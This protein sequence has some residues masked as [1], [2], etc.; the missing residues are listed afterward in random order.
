[1]REQFQLRDRID[2]L[3]QRARNKRASKHQRRGGLERITAWLIEAFKRKDN[4]GDDQGN[5]GSPA[6][7]RAIVIPYGMTI[8]G[9]KCGAIAQSIGLYDITGKS[10]RRD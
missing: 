10:G 3:L 5:A 4:A 8:E 1:M 9:V 7:D 2:Q 6:P